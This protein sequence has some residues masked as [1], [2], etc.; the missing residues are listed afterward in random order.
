ME[1]KGNSSKGIIKTLTF[2]KWDPSTEFGGVGVGFWVDSIKDPL[3]FESVS[4][5]VSSL[6]DSIAKYCI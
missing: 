2:T 4:L 5:I 3:V 6:G 1:R